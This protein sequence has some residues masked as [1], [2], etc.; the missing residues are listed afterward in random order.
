MP[1][2]PAEYPGAGPLPPGN[3]GDRRPDGGRPAGG[4]PVIAARGLA[5]RFGAVAA[6]TGIDI[7]VRAGTIHALVGENGA[8]KST[9]GRIL[10]GAVQPDGG[11][12]LVD[13]EPVRLVSPRAALRA[14]VTTISQELT[15]VPTLTVIDN[16]FLGTED[17]HGG[18]LSGRAAR[19]RYRELAGRVGFELPPQARVRELGVADQQKAEILRAIARNARVVVMDEPTA[20]LGR[21]EVDQLMRI[22][23]EMAARGTAVVYI[24]HALDEVLALAHVVT[25]MRDG[26]IVATAAA[27]D[28]TPASLA[29]AML[30]RPLDLEFPARTPPPPGAP[31]VC[32]VSGL[33][34]ERAFE[35]VSFEVR[36]GEIVGLA[37][38]AGSGCAEVARVLA[39]AERAQAGRV[40]LGGRPVRLRSPR[41]AQTHGVSLLPESRREQGLFMNRPIRENVSAGRGAMV[42]SFGWV[43]PRREKTRVTSLLS[44]FDVRMSSVD[45]TVATLSGGNQQ[46]VLLAKC[47]FGRPKVL[48]AVQPTRGVDV[49]ARAG[50]YR[51]L[52]RMAAEGL[53]V[54]LVSSEM[55][56]VH[57]LAHRIL[58]FRRGRVT[59]ELDPGRTSHRELMNHVVGAASGTDGG[60]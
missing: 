33:G 28:E 30:G 4:R 25:V 16:V 18:L 57:G 35:D 60:N 6:L 44:E 45:A 19:R 17:R 51:L 47:A 48:V 54:V 8:G 32:E 22:T 42:A 49:G 21:R 23:R 1:A 52:V 20:A 15:L 55:E 5:K 38:L 36:A 39:G 3:S 11:R 34:R 56:E 24:A 9:L 2:E 26:R 40:V 10:A 14:G 59:A 41:D 37:G 13:G 46:K 43:R 27:R 50:I 29:A 7:D 58:V 53:G 31:V 12:I